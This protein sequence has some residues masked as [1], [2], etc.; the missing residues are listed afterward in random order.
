MAT[1]TTVKVSGD[2][3]AAANDT[4]YS[5]ISATISNHNGTRIGGGQGPVVTAHPGTPAPFSFTVSASG[6]P[7]SC[8]ISWAAGSA[9]GAGAK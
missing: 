2:L 3:K 9:P 7:G 1:G 4:A 6:T 5:G 8:T